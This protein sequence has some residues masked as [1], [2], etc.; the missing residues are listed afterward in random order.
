MALIEQ[1]KAATAHLV[2]YGGV[3]WNPADLPPGVSVED[4]EPIG[5]YFKNEP[6]RTA[7]A[8]LEALAVGKATEH[9]RRQAEIAEQKARSVEAADLV[10]RKAEA[11][12]ANADAHDPPQAPA[13]QARKKAATPAAKE[14]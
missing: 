5:D 4:C 9:E 12:Q 8:L 1:T 10:A 3:Q 6:A 11:V 2:I 7:A 13:K 14:K